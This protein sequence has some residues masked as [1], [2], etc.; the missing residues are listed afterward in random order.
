MFPENVPVYVECRI[1]RN[2]MVSATEVESGGLFGNFQ[3]V[4]STRTAL[5]EMVHPK[6]PT[7]V[8]TE[9]T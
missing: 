1:T 5:A 6:P 4:E 8:E 3:R 9:I 2:G 7:P